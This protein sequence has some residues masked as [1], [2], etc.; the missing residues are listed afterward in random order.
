MQEGQFLREKQN[1]DDFLH[2]AGKKEK[3]HKKN[4]KG[5]DK[6]VLLCYYVYSQD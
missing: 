3:K 2:R 1:I 4:E 6:P 5:L